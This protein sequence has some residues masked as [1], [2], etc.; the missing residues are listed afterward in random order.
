LSEPERREATTFL[1]DQST[2]HPIARTPLIGQD[3]PEFFG[4]G[5][6]AMCASTY[7]RLRLVLFWAMSLF[8]GIQVIFASFS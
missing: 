6:S 1:H 5:N 8:I 7:V 3:K 4:G 2:A